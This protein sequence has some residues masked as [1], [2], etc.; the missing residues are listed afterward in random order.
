MASQCTAYRPEPR[1]VKC[2]V[3]LIVER[4]EWTRGCQVSRKAWHS[5]VRVGATTHS[6]YRMSP[7]KAGAGATFRI[8]S[9]TC[10]LNLDPTPRDVLT[11]AEPTIASRAVVSE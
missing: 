6:S 10:L 5:R 3:H 1:S 11:P 7:C 9:A 8:G 4:N 2:S